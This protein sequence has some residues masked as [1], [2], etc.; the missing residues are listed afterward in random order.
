MI[1][2]SS[3]DKKTDSTN[4]LVEQQ[5]PENLLI[6]N[7][8]EIDS[9]SVDDTHTSKKMSCLENNKEF[10]FYKKHG[11]VRVDGTH[12]FC[13]YTKD[14]IK[15]SLLYI[16]CE[17]KSRFIKNT[18]NQACSFTKYY[19]DS[20]K[21]FDSVGKNGDRVISYIRDLN[22]LVYKGET[23]KPGLEFLPNYIQKELQR[24]SIYQRTNL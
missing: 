24:K 7:E 20:L 2:C 21:M 11:E 10:Q 22:I 9:I 8:L 18:N 23:Y 17:V 16:H 14:S 13:S 4:A 6:E 1:S 12:T 5:E 3:T 19:N 15:Y